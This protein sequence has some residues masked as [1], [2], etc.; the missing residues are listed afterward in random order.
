MLCYITNEQR[1]LSIKYAVYNWH[2]VTP[3]V[4][5]WIIYSN[6]TIGWS[7]A[8]GFLWINCSDEFFRILLTW[9]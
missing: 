5:N 9:R 4:Y 3:Y 1:D 7:G 6:K 2:K 8:N